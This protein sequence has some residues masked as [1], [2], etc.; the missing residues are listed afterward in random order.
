[1][2]SKS[3][4]KGNRLERDV[5]DALNKAFHTEEFARTPSSGAIMGLS[6]YQKNRNLEDS[7]KRALGSDIICPSWFRFSIECKNYNDKPNLSKLINDED[8]DLNG[9]VGEALF[10]AINMKRTPLLVFR[11]TRKGTFVVL[12]FVFN[13]LIKHQDFNFLRYKRDFV[14]LNFESFLQ[15]STIFHEWNELHYEDIQ[16]WLERSTVVAQMV[17]QMLTKKGKKKE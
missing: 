14:I 12:P 4:S 10:D 17:E 5:R 1:M 13:E 15:S 8:N 2:T 7:T 16:A 9:W 11:T 3:K 6:N